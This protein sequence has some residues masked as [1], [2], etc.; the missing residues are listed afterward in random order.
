MSADV[1]NW[2]NRNLVRASWAPLC[3]AQLQ[4]LGSLLGD[5]EVHARARADLV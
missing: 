1:F 2:L 3:D 4:T 5:D